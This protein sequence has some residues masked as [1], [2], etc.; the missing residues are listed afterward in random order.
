[1]RP[2]GASSNSMPH[3]KVFPTIKT[4]LACPDNEYQNNRIHWKRK[5]QRKMVLFLQP[6]QYIM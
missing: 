4:L 6:E 3:L 5:K 1:M 2:T